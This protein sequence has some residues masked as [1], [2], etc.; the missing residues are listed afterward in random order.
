MDTVGSTYDTTLGRLHRHAVAALTQRHLERRHRPRRQCPEPRDLRGHRRHHLPDQIDGFDGDI[1]SIVL[2][3]AQQGPPLFSSVKFSASTTSVSEAAG[4]VTVTVTRTGDTPS[5]QSVQYF[6]FDVTTS[7]FSDYTNTSG[8]IFWAAG[9]TSRDIT[10]PLVN[11]ATAEPDETFN[12]MLQNASGTGLSI[13]TPSTI[14]VTITNDD[15]GTPGPNTVQFTSSNFA[16]TEGFHTQLNIFV[17]RTGDVAQAASVDYATSNVTASDRSD[18]LAAYG[19]LRWAPGETASKEI[20]VFIVDD[21]YGNTTTNGQS[22]AAVETFN[23]TLSNPVGCTTGSPDQFQ[24]SIA[25]NET[26]DGGNPVKAASFIPQFFVRQHYLDF[27]NREPDA[28]GLDFWTNQI[29]RLRRGRPVRSARSQRLRPPSSS[30]IEFQET[31]YLVYQIYQ[32]AYG[33]RPNEP[34]P[35]TLRE[36]LPDTQQVGRGVIVG[37]PGAW[38]NGSKRTRAASPTRSSRARASPRYPC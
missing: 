24:V 5:G 1:G 23:I 21:S 28:A 19:T 10:I 36:F 32:A 22:D 20:S 34:V 35:S 38:P 33:G 15:S 29:D 17:S 12:V 11:D 18:Y 30:P 3:W 27:L 6:T 14:G 4:S 9:E 8:T 37:A 2:N 7:V 25:N 13:G 26:A 31:G 16:A